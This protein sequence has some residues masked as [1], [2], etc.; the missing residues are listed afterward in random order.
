MAVAAE[1]VV[2]LVPQESGHVTPHRHPVVKL[3][4]RP[5]SAIAARKEQAKEL[6]VVAVLVRLRVARVGGNHAARFRE[7]S[8]AA[9]LPVVVAQI[10]PVP[11]VEF[12]LE[13]FTEES[14]THMRIC[15]GRHARS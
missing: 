3:A 12:A 10:L 11:N 2:Q 14:Y 13:A 5:V 1:H 8:P 15:K 6:G 9:S 4:A 7:G